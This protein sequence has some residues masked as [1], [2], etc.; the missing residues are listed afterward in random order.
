MKMMKNKYL[1]IVLIMKFLLFKIK[2]ESSLV[3]VNIQEMH[4]S[5]KK[6]I[7]KGCFYYLNKYII[8]K[9]CNWFI[10]IRVTF[11][12]LYFYE[13]VHLGRHYALGKTGFPG[14]E[15]LFICL[16]TIVAFQYEMTIWKY[17]NDGLIE[18]DCVNESLK[19]LTCTLTQ[20]YGVK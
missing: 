12:S 14:L 6:K 15:M 17:I 20:K 16:A 9:I 5:E 2:M 19:Q 7:K 3:K 10:L 11:L 4:H 8:Q 1:Y 13:T 18:I